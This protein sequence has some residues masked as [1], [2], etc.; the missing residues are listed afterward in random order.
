MPTK[1]LII[2]VAALL[3]LISPITAKACTVT[4]PTCGSIVLLPTDFIVEV[5]G[6]VDP[7][8]VQASD[9]MVNGA[10]ASAFIITNGNT[11]ITFHF[12]TSPVVTG[13]NS[14]FIPAGALSCGP[15]S[16]FSCKFTSF[17]IHPTPPPGPRPTPTSRPRPVPRL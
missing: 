1:A 5:S 9:L 12:N 13:P 16:D 8:T 4:S 14:M 3:E 17:G 11:T 6:P 10:P 2:T 7:V 15:P